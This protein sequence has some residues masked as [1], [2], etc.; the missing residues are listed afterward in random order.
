[1]MYFIKVKQLRKAIHGNHHT[2]V[3]VSDTARYGKYYQ[4]NKFICFGI[5]SDFNNLPF[6]H[7]DHL[8]TSTTRKESN[9]LFEALL[10]IS[11]CLNYTLFRARVVIINFVVDTVVSFER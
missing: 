2:P 1:M 5:S 9:T 8:I 6:M 10:K 4:S 7:L 3:R 11:T